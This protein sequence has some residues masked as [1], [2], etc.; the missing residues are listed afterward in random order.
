MKIRNY[1]LFDSVA[2][3]FLRPFTATTD[4][5]AIRVFTSWV[6][7][8]EKKTNVAI[9]PQHY[10]LFY[11]GTFD[12]K[13]ALFETVTPKELIIGVVCKEPQETYTIADLIKVITKIEHSK[14]EKVSTTLL[15]K[16]TSEGKN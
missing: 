13:T 3:I 8:P 12:D 1:V 6:N 11:V 7:D 4:A 2:E 5:D 16:L 15:D 10:T 9:Y 14:N